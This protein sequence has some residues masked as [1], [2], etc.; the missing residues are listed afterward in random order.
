MAGRL[1]SNLEKRFDAQRASAEALVKE[2]HG[3][4]AL[5]ILCSFTELECVADVKLEGGW[6]RYI[7]IEGGEGEG[8]D[9]LRRIG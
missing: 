8:D 2:E 1:K 5:Q 9:S 4:D 3:D 7:L 6:I